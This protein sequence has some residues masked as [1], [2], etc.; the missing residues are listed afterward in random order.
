MLQNVSSVRY[1]GIRMHQSQHEFVLSA[2]RSCVAIGETIEMA[3][4]FG[5]WRLRFDERWT[6][7]RQRKAWGCSQGASNRTCGRVQPEAN[8]D[9]SGYH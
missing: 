7:S 1:V 6:L 3:M 2:L 8:N 9:E 5:S 4:L